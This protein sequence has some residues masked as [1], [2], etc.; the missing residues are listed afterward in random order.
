[1]TPSLFRKILLLSIFLTIVGPSL[2]LIFPHLVPTPLIQAQEAIEQSAP[3]MNTLA[4]IIA[5]IL[6]IITGIMATVGL[7]AFRPWAPKV[8]LGFTLIS[9]AT[10][11]ILGY[12]LSSGWALMLTDTS[13]MLWGAV[14]ALV[15]YSPMRRYFR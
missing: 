5:A 8:A 7:F 6:L 15:F 12:V 2:D 4:L 13:L 14:L 11:P 3:F 9:F 1:M 10:Y